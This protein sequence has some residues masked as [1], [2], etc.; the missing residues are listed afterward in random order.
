MRKFVFQDTP[1]CILD[2]EKE[3]NCN[4]EGRYNHRLH[5]VMLLLRGHTSLEAA[6]IFGDN[7]RTIKHW[8]QQYKRYGLQGLKEA[9]RPGRPRKLLREY[10]D[11]IKSDLLMP[12][13]SFGYLQGFWDGP[14]L[15]HHLEKHY[16]VDITVRHC[17]RLF[18]ELDMSLKRPRPTMAGASPEKQEDFKKNSRGDE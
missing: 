17:Q 1:A 18:H 6:Q 10:L 15:K 11:N 16:N 3:I 8:G 7:P 4:P 14:L 2:I 5:S 9:K 12:T 13:S